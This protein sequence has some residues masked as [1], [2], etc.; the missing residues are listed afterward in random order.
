MLLGVV[1]FD[2]AHKGISQLV[3]TVLSDNKKM[4]DLFMES[5]A[6]RQISQEVFDLTIAIHKRSELYPGTPTGTAFKNI[7]QL[8]YAQ[9]R[10][11]SVTNS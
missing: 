5:G 3:A 10:G 11:Q 6:T 4:L 7:Y 2:A 1:A 8:L 9:W